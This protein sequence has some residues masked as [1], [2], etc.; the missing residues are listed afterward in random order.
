MWLQLKFSGR[1]AVHSSLGR[2]QPATSWLA[3]TLG[4][5]LCDGMVLH[6]GGGC[7]PIFGS[8]LAAA[9]R[10]G[11]AALGDFGIC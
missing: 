11:V 1:S 2:V 4:G 6:T 3:S 8:P 7:M 9:C 10:F 5:C